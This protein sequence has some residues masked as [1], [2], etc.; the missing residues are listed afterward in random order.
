MKVN[1]TSIENGYFVTIFTPKKD[2]IDED[3][4]AYHTWGEV[5][6]FLSMHFGEK[7]NS[8]GSSHTKEDKDE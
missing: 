6:D 3:V 4:Y 7:H 5:V 1:I 2:K 8:M